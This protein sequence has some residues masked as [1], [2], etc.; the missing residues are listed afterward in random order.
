VT[1]GTSGHSPDVATARFRGRIKNQ[2]FGGAMDLL[3]IDCGNS[4]VLRARIATPGPLS[5]ERE[6]E[7]SANDAVRVRDGSED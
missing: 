4:Q 3:E 1:P 6:F 5:G 2:T 7:F